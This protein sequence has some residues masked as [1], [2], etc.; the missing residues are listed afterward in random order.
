MNVIRDWMKASKLKLNPEKIKVLLVKK[1]IQ[2]LNYPPIFN[3]VA[4][5]LQNRYAVWEFSGTLSSL[6]NQ[7]TAVTRNAFTC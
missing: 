2:I 4:L 3:E 5:P 1:S 7:V 6:E